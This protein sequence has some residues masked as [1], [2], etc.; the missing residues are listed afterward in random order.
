MKNYMIMSSAVFLFLI[1]L[2]SSA[3]A[4]SQTMATQA[5]VV[6]SQNATN[7][8]SDPLAMM[9]SVTDKL[10][11]TLKQQR[12]RLRKDPN[13][14]YTIVDNILI[15]YVDVQDMARTAAGRSAWMGATAEQQQAFAKAFLGAVVRT[16]ATAL[17]AY[18]DETVKYDPIRGG[19]AGRRN[20]TIS[21]QIIRPNAPA[22]A[23]SYSLS[24]NGQEWRVYDMS[25]EGVS[26]LSSFHSQIQSLLS[27]GKSLVDITNELNKQSK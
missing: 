10:L 8:A 5:T 24:N 18:N 7:T 9:R 3:Y 20:V 23:V 22:V 1:T 15:P 13:Y 11:A 26:L 14:I 4:A 19:V 2:N 6:K 12:Q 25:V 21:S 16:Y 17:D 27:R